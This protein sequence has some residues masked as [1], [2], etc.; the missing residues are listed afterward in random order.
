[1]RLAEFDEKMCP[2]SNIIVHSNAGRIL[3]GL[4]SFALR[5]L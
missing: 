4:V 2:L 3:V 5:D 1:M